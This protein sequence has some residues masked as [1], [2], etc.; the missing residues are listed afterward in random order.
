MTEGIETAQSTGVLTLM[1]DSYCKAHDLPHE[2]A[3]ELQLQLLEQIEELK[4]HAQW[5]QRFITRWD[6]VQA[7]EDI[8][9]C[10]RTGHTDTGRGVCADCGE[11]I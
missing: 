9:Y 10:K 8:A 7:E 11:F 1:L 5:L 4:L 3:D 6:A 2:S